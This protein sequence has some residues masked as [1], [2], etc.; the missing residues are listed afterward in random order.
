MKMIAP[1]AVGLSF[2]AAMGCDRLYSNKKP[3]RLRR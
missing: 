3:W 1:L 2:V